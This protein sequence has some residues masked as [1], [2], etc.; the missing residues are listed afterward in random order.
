MHG[1][2]FDFG[3]ESI[4]SLEC[5]LSSI[6]CYYTSIYFRQSRAG[7][8]EKD[9]KSQRYF[10]VCAPITTELHISHSNNRFFAGPGCTRITST[11]RCPYFVYVPIIRIRY[12]NDK[13]VLAPRRKSSRIGAHKYSVAETTGFLAL[14]VY[15]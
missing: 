10:L 9:A 7:A 11:G 3:I 4:H 8:G 13:N 15:L 14:I 5:I 2:A 1:T 12:W 6:S